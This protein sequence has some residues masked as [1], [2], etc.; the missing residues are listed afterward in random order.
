VSDPGAYEKVSPAE[1]RDRLQAG[2]DVR[3]WDHDGDHSKVLRV[4]AGGNAHQG[5]DSANTTIWVQGS[6]REIALR[7]NTR[8][9]I[10]VV[11]ETGHVDVKC[12]DPECNGCMFCDGGLWACTVCGGLEGAMPST[13]PGAQMDADTTDAVYAGQKDFRDGAWVDEC[14][15]FSPA[16]FAK[17]RR[18]A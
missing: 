3:L 4:D 15:R 12:T 2:R 1:P 16:H 18:E 5:I 17:Y 9:A 10:K 6:D 13:C 7:V 14:S 8:A 11:N